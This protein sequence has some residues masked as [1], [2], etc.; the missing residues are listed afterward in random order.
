MPK[1]ETSPTPRSF[2]ICGI[3]MAMVEIFSRLIP[4]FY[5]FSL[6]YLSDRAFSLALVPV[7]LSQSSEPPGTKSL[8]L[9]C[10][11]P[12]RGHFIHGECCGI[13][14]PGPLRARTWPCPTPRSRKASSLISRVGWSQGPLFLSSKD[15]CLTQKYS[16]SESRACKP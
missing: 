8:W 16:I 11:A 9:H 14:G 1:L 15:V 5:L 2:L 6:L 7:Y 10:P 3:S 12:G 4:A 13:S